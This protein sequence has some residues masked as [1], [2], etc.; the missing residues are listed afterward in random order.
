MNTWNGRNAQDLAGGGGAVDM[1]AGHRIVSS[2]ENGRIVCTAG[3][4][5]YHAR[6]TQV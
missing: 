5:G 2:E 3:L 6:I 1:G 4:W